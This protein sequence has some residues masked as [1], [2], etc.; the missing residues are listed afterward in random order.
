MKIYDISMEIRED[1]VVYK[2][3]T[4]KKP[5]IEITSTTKTG[6]ANE[7]RVHLDAHTGTHADAPFHFLDEGQTIDKV[8]AEKFIG[9]C[10]VIDL[11]KIEKRGIERKDLVNSKIKKGDIVILKTSNKYGRTFDFEFVFLAES[12]AKHLV[13][14]NVK[15]VGINAL[16]IERSQPEYGTHKSLLSE[17]IIIFEGLELSKIKPG[18]YFFVGLPLKIKVGDGSPIRAVLVKF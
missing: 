10:I 5:K 15:S 7:S 13:S 9:D 1:M 18:R 6:N 14:K 16:G 2:N 12:G 11:S 4:E 8:S 17:G 3:K